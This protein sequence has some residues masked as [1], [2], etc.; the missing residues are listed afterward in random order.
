M[1]F[2]FP[3]CLFKAYIDDVTIAVKNDITV[4]HSLM[5]SFESHAGT[6]RLS[7]NRK[8]CQIIVPDQTN[9][10]LIV[11]REGAE[12]DIIRAN[13]TGDKSIANYHIQLNLR[14][15]GFLDENII[16]NN[17]R[18][19]KENI[20]MVILGV[21]VGTNEYKTKFFNEKIDEYIKEASC[22]KNLNHYQ[23][24]WCIFLYCLQSKITHLLRLIHPDITIPLLGRLMQ[25]D[26]RLLLNLFDLNGL[27]N[28][29]K[30]KIASQFYF[31]ISEGGFQKKNYLHTAV[32]AYLGSALTVF[33]YVQKEV[34]NLFPL[35]NGNSWS[36]NLSCLLF[37]TR[38]VIEG[39]SIILPS[40]NDSDDHMGHIGS[41][42]SSLM[43]AN[44]QGSYLNFPFQKLQ[45]R[46]SEVLYNRVTKVNERPPPDDSSSASSDRCNQFYS[47]KWLFLAPTPTTFFDNHTFR[48]A[49]AIKLNLDLIE[50]GNRKCPACLKPLDSKGHHCL[51]CQHAE[52]KICHNNVRDVVAEYFSSMG[53]TVFV[54]EIPINALKGIR[55]R[56]PASQINAPVATASNIISNSPNNNTS[57]QGTR[58]DILAYK[59]GTNEKPICMDTQVVNSV[60]PSFISMEHKEARKEDLHKAAV[61]AEGGQYFPPTFDCFGNPSKNTE[62][63]LKSFYD[64]YLVSLPPNSKALMLAEGRQT[65]YWFTKISFVI[66]HF[67]AFQTNVL[68]NNL[69][70][71]LGVPGNPS[72]A[73]S[74]HRAQRMMRRIAGSV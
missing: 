27:D 46:F 41:Y 57:T 9:S 67:K 25:F 21:P 29:L 56:N 55:S 17:P 6:I 24:Q 66:N 58:F 60:A 3:D 39:N 53:Y 15:H 35:T 43:T 68:L 20:G 12:N 4:V 32:S 31:K 22:I 13:E 49:I 18:E 61:E 14:N 40:I 59:P 34:K 62:K 38:Q 23:S 16:H 50:E 47:G 63:L 72:L 44:H 54:G 37:R 69:K 45:K 52:L 5:K 42:L 71:N 7:L 48:T 2:E 36:Y 11:L 74:H 26:A 33:S 28:E 73:L 19:V 70:G 10:R 1:Q 65:N 51:S 64:R 30:K 8:K